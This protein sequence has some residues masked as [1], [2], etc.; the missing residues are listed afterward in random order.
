MGFSNH[1]L[2]RCAQPLQEVERKLQEAKDGSPQHRG[3][4]PHTPSRENESHASRSRSA[5]SSPSHKS[6]GSD[7]Q[8]PQDPFGDCQHKAHID[9]GMR[10]SK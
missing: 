3:S 1:S 2:Y 9:G 4:R 5:S 10:E 6:E 8:A 7:E